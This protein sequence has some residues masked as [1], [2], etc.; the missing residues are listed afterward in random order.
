MED[1]RPKATVFMLPGDEQLSP[2][3]T[4]EGS[5]A[6]SD[7]W[8]AMII[9]YRKKGEPIANIHQRYAGD[10]DFPEIQWL[11]GQALQLNSLECIK[12]Q[13]IIDDQEGL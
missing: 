12:I 2:R 7:D 4:L 13:S 6:E 1:K 9:V 3:V 10:I 11:L 8:E 5:L